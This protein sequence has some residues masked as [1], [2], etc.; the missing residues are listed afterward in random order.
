[1]TELFHPRRDRWK[2]HWERAGLYLVGKPAIGRTTVRVLTMNSEDQLM[3]REIQLVGNFRYGNVFDEAIRLVAAGRVN[4]RP[5]IT[6]LFPLKDT[7]QAMV[8]AADKAHALK[9]QIEVIP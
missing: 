6:G 3:V 9:V 5:F 4:L 7:A 8:Q 1:M 2:D